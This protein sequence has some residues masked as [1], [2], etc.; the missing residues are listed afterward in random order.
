MHEERR[1]REPREMAGAQLSRFSWRM[2]GIGQQQQPGQPWEI[3]GK[4]RIGNQHGCLPATVGV[5]TEKNAARHT[6]PNDIGRAAQ[7]L[8]I[9]GGSS[10]KR[11]PVRARL[12]KGQVASQHRK[13]SFGK[14]AGYSQ[15]KFGLA[16]RS[17]AVGEHKRVTACASREMKEAANRRLGGK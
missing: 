16:I 9:T 14:C 10:G 13:S 8:S 2:E 5:A 1:N 17:R 6:L 15:Q 4:L 12:A 11:R 7:P 3:I